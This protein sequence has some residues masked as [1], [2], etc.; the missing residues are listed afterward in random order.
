[1]THFVIKV[2]RLLFAFIFFI[3]RSSFFLSLSSFISLSIYEKFQ[4]TQNVTLLIR[5]VTRQFA[6]QKRFVKRTVKKSPPLKNG[7]FLKI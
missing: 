6:R 1:M 4:L 5:I 3:F 2:S 7:Y